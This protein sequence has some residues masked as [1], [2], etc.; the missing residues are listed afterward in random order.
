MN[1][2]NGLWVCEQEG[3]YSHSQLPCAPGAGADV[4]ILVSPQGPVTWLSWAGLGA[5]MGKPWC[6]PGGAFAHLGKMDEMHPDD[7]LCAGSG[8]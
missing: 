1:A 7:E 6:G 5:K 2:V 8:L 4:Y 3:S